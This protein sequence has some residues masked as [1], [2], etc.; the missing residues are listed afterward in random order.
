M[1]G[2]VRMN[3]PIPY[4]W[5]EGS[6]P[7]ADVAKPARTHVV[8]GVAVDTTASG[9][10]KVGGRSVHAVT[11]DS[12]GSERGREGE[13]QLHYSPSGDHLLSRAKDIRD[14]SIRSREDLVDAEDGSNVD[15]SVN[16]GSASGGARRGQLLRRLCLHQ[17]PA[18]SYRRYIYSRSIKGVEDDAVLAAV[19]NVDDDGVVDLLRDED[20]ALAW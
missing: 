19:G 8:E 15:T 9:D 14:G 18:T 17:P 4:R 16:V 2:W 6:A 5:G 3:S 10:D 11:I 12:K 13:E 20:G 7:S 1:L